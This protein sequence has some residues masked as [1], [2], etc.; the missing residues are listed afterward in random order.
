MSSLI[1]NTHTK[2][3]FGLV[4]IHTFYHSSLF[5]S[6]LHVI[7]LLHYFSSFFTSCSRMINV[8]WYVLVKIQVY[9]LHWNR[10]PDERHTSDITFSSCNE[11]SGIASFFR[12]T[13]CDLRLSISPLQCYLILC[14]IF[15]EYCEFNSQS[16]VQ[17]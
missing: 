11:I 1:F 12:Q 10:S 4:S 2:T 8:T 5:F 16:F 6:L 15:S 17:D 14:N 13:V 9:I 3:Q 7:K